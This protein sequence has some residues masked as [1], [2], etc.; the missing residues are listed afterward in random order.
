MKKIPII[1]LF[2]LFLFNLNA[3]PA[4][5]SATIELSAFKN[6]EVASGDV[7]TTVAITALNSQPVT[8]RSNEFV[9]LDESKDLFDNYVLEDAFAVT[10]STNSKTAVNVNLTLTPFVNLSNTQI[11]IP[12]TYTYHPVTPTASTE[13]AS[14]DTT[15]I[16]VGN[17]YKTCNRFSYTPS[18]T[19]K[20]SDNSIVSA[21]TSLTITEELGLT[22]TQR[23]V[24]LSFYYDNSKHTE[25]TIPTEY[26]K[27]TSWGR[28]K[29][30]ALSTQTI[31][32]N[33]NSPSVSTTVKFNLS[34]DS[35]YFTTS[36]PNKILANQYYASTVTLTISGT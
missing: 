18:I 5:S 15:Y 14:S 3:E 28:T 31:P 6:G 36:N 22:L 33:G 19:L 10:I 11:S 26:T 20:R 9:I 8:G 23:I 35:S 12:A 2:L 27:K 25:T 4:T 24:S 30:E 17:N 32:P 16:K 1:V 29:Y 21:N 13:T 7:I 34:V